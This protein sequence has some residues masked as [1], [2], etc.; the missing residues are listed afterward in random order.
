[1]L[2]NKNEKTTVLSADNIILATGATSKN[3]PFLV[4]D[5]NLIWDYKSA[6]IPKELPNS[7]I[8]IVSISE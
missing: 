5:Y 6:L 4:A 7:L 3:L 2:N 8:I 1:M